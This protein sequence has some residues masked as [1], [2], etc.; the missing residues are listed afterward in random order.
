MNQ[1]E[2]LRR[3]WLSLARKSAD[4]HKEFKALYYKTQ[5]ACAIGAAAFALASLAFGYFL[6][7]QV[8]WVGI[9]SSMACLYFVRDFGMEGRKCTE[10]WLKYRDF[11]LQMADK[12][13]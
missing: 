13:R 3:D 4:Y 9:P 11:D 2:S 8:Y 6:G 10:R 1:R 5:L 12:F 7:W